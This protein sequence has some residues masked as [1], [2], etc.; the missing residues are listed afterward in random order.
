MR[1]RI[2]GRHDP[3]LLAGLAFALLV[4][5]QPSIQVGL[6]A[7]RQIERHYGVAL[8]PAL[9]LLS[10]MFI[11][12]QHAARR[13]MKAEAAAAASEAALARARANE[14]EHMMRFGQALTRARSIEAIRETAWLHMPGLLGT[15]EVWVLLRGDGGWERLGDRSYTQWPSGEIEDL[16]REVIGK[17]MEG[18]APADGVECRG[19]ICFAM[20]TDE[21][22]LGVVGVTSA[23]A[24][25]RDADLRRKVG[26][27]AALLAVAI[28]NVRLFAEV[29][30][31]SVRD[32]LT[33]CFNRAHT[34]DILDAEVGR[35]RRSSAP[36]SL[37]MFD[38][39]NFKTVNDTHGHL[40][41]DAVLAAVGQRL[42]NILR[43]SD[44]RCRYGGDEFLVVLPETPE[45]GAIR[46]AEWIRV[47][48]EQIRIDSPHQIPVSVSVGVASALGADTTTAAL[49]ERADRALYQAKA[50]GRNCVRTAPAAARAVSSIPV[51]PQHALVAH[52][53]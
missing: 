51:V 16:A 49:I 15:P 25:P 50:A 53:L 4:I 31:H 11:F 12:H 43:K 5:F 34:V 22:P 41:G 35:S 7:A 38:V 10:V 39:D 42:R 27:A 28:D 26:A 32:A 17:A 8:I 47:E 33:G 48:I 46:V 9:M 6:D 21:R 45:A 23:G 3:L 24:A 2:T 36:L 29:Q 52:S 19:H 40:S 18:S 1:L 37:L 30:E 14:L 20:V 44:V 13:E